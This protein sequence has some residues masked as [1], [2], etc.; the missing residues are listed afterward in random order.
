MRAKARVCTR[1]RTLAR[2]NIAT[3]ARTHARNMNARTHGRTC[4][5]YRHTRTSN[6]RAWEAHTNARIYDARTQ[7]RT[8]RRTWATGLVTCVRTRSASLALPRHKSRS[9]TATTAANSR[10]DRFAIARYSGCLWCCFPSL[11]GIFCC[12]LFVSRC[13]LLLWLLGG[14]GATCLQRQ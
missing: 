7:A 4:S 9:C 11:R 14:V 8:Q 1:A 2:T 10:R 3:L 13:F 12:C 5:A 6:K